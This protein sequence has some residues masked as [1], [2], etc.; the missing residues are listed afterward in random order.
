MPAHDLL[1]SF[2]TPSRGAVDLDVRLGEGVPRPARVAGA[3][4]VH[5]V[6]ADP[7]GLGDADDPEVVDADARLLV[8]VRDEVSVRAGQR[9]RGRV[10]SRTWAVMAAVTGPSPS[11]A[12]ISS[13]TAAVAAARS[14]RAEI[15]ARS[16]VP[17]Q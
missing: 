6:P 12:V 7:H 4:L 15:S 1:H 2:G 16:G 10:A 11:S 8:S 17:P 14:P 3:P 5:G 13:T 9:Q